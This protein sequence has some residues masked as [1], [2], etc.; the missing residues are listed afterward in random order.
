MFVHTLHS[1]TETGDRYDVYRDRETN[2][3]IVHDYADRGGANFL[4]TIHL[5][6]SGR[7]LDV[8]TESRVFNTC[9]AP[10]TWGSDDTLL[11]RSLESMWAKHKG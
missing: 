7:G 4:G 6:Y 5:Y 3:T 8:D 2:R 1:T 11:Q 9:S 10:L